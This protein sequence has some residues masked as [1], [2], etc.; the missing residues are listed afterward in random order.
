MT[1]RLELRLGTRDFHRSENGTMWFCYDESGAWMLGADGTTWWCDFR[2]RVGYGDTP[3][4][5]YS[6]L[7]AKLRTEA[8]KLRAAVESEVAA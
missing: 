3:E 2:D 1:P 6:S 5:A 4:E 8:D 7:I